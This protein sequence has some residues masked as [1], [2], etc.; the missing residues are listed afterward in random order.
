MGAFGGKPSKSGLS[1]HLLQIFMKR[2]L[3]D[4]YAYAAHPMGVPDKSRHPI[5]EHLQTSGGGPGKH[6]RGQVRVVVHPTA[7][8]Q[9]TKVRMFV[10]SADE[11]FHKNRTT[12]Q[13]LTTA[14]LAPVLGSKEA[15]LKAAAGIFGGTLPSWFKPDDQREEIKSAV[16]KLGS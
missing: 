6:L 3:V 9:A 13:E 5:G 2:H 4:K 15:R 16:K 11:E 14:L 8:L 12:F 7:F 10:Y 1:G